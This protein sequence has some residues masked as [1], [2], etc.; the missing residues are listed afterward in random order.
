MECPT[1]HSEN[2]ADSRYCGKCGA[3]LGLAGPEQPSLTKTLV[4]PLPVISKGSLIAGKYKIIDEIG[5]GGMGIVYK[6]EDVKLQRCIALKFLPLHLMD[7]PELRE[8]LLIEARAAAALS[9]PNICVI[10]EVGEGEERP[11]IAME[12]VEGETLGDKIK[13]GPLKTEEALGI[14]IQ[15][16]EGLDEAHG[17][18][19][20][21]RDIKSANIMI[22]GKGQA[23]VMDFGLAKVKGGPLLTREGTTLGTVSYMSPEQARGEA[24]DQRT[25]LWS[26]GVVLYEMLSG[27]LPVQGERETSIL[28]SIVHEEPKQLKAVMPDV[29]VEIERIIRRALAKMPESRYSSAG[30]MLKDLQGYQ[31]A[32]KAVEAGAFNLRSL[33]RLVR[34]PQV[35]FPAL[36]VIL[37]F[38]ILGVWFTNRQAK[39]RYVREQ[40]LPK[41]GQLIEGGRDNFIAAYKLAAQAEKYMPQDAKL[42]GLISQ[43][44]VKISVTT[45]PPGAKV[46]IKEYKT[47]DAPWEYLGISPV[48]AVRLPIGFFRWKAEKEEYET[49]LAA[50]PDFELDVKSQGLTVPNNFQRVLDKAGSIPPGMVRIA[51]TQVVR[52]GELGDFFFDRYEITNRQFKEFVDKG[53]YQKKEYWKQKFIQDGKELTWEVALKEFVDQTG[54]PGPSTWQAGDYP[55]GQDDYPVSGVS[56]Y[57][58]AAYAEF[59][60]KSLPTI[61]HWE[62]AQGF[63]ALMLSRGIYMLLAPLSNFKNEGLVPVG[64][65]PGMTGY[66]NFD[67]AG[68]VREWC[69]NEAPKGR[70]IRGGAWN[71]ATYMFG[72]LSQATPFDRSAKNGFRCAIYPGRDKIPGAAF[73][74]T[75][76]AEAPD[77]YELKPVPDSVFQIYKEQF[78]Y[79][80]TDLKSKV[81]WRNENSRDWVEEKITFNAAYNNERMMAYL[82]LPKSSPPPYQTVIYFPG[83]GSISQKTSENLDRYW[84]YDSRLSAIVKNGRAALYPVYKGTFE[85]GDED[86]SSADRSSHLFTEWLVKIVKDFKRCVD[87]LETRPDIDSHKLAYFG[88]S[89]GGKMGS[90]I[91]AVESRLKASVLHVGGLM[92]VGRPEVNDFNYVMRVK[93]PTLM[94]NGKYDLVFPLGTSAKPLFDLL[95][96]PGDQKKMIVYDTDHS[97]PRNE[98]IKET[99]NWLDKYLGPVR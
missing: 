80:K 15:V 42:S 12:Y 90:I 99:L 65:L 98:Y 46:Y 38:V 77:F 60:G 63:S 3:P 34:R 75:K 69:W 45:E 93:I 7:S 40:L 81:E 16:A 11:Y 5:H 55:Q 56:W 76:L 22:T 9:H 59:M 85:R 23:K 96:T 87:Y 52:V 32:R 8:R 62:I 95:G 33:W 4:T 51:G 79:D 68:N 91:P 83:V 72:Y 86:L 19:I 35:A 82:F 43:I 2:A 47:P 21:H 17:K 30:E 1:C 50:A 6:A 97:I 58:A 78:S 29:S 27:R 37:A 64:S 28:Y 13:S 31:E 53:G 49:V 25:D 24:V 20:I 39:I 14:A 54:R 57:E 89:W 84:E 41:I 61:H 71:D 36:I 67:M 26:L 48:D 94:L 92:G 73:E 66:G 18:G 70:I 74:P 88:F 10:Y 44:T